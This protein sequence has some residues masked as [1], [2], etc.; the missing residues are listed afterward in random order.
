MAL[1]SDDININTLIGPGSAVAGNLR[2]AGFVRIDGDIAGDRN[3]RK[4][5]Y[6]RTC[7]D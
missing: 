6:R 5:N 2:V 3:N 1:S 7:P 4:G